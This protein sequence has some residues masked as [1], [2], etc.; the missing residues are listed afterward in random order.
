[1]LDYELGHVHFVAQLFEEI[2]RRDAAEVL[3]ERVR[4]PIEFASQ[5]EFVRQVLRNEVG[6]GARDDI[7]CRAETSRS[8]LGTPIAHQQRRFSVEF[9]LGGLHVPP[10]DRDLRRAAATSP[11]ADAIRAAPYEPLHGGHH[12]RS[13][14]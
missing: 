3:D 7:S 4:Q 14:R 9:G 11:R 10:R 13:S 12:Q 2:E 5:R 6:L 1:M 8:A